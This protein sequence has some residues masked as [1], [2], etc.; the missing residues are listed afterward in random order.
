MTVPWAEAGSR[1]TA[2]F[3]ALVIDW[4]KEATTKAVAQQMKLSW[5]AADGIQQRAVKRG[6]ERRE[7]KPPKRIAVDETSFQCRF[8]AYASKFR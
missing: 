4:L 6:L 7:I 8:L 1:Y 3:E 5:T 2:L